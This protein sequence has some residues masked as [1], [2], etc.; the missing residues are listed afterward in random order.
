VSYLPICAD[1]GWRGKRT[2]TSGIAAHAG[3]LHSCDTYLRSQASHA[4]GQQLRAAVDRTPKP[5]HHKQANHQHGTHAC[6]VLDRCRCHPCKDANTA[7]ERTRSRQTAYG[8]WNPYVDAQPV[9]D[10]VQQLTAAGMGLKTIAKRSHV[11]HGA[12]WKLMY[13]KTRPDGTRQPSIKVRRETAQALLQLRPDLELLA[14]VAYVDATGTHRRIQALMAAGW[15]LS[16]QAQH[17]GVA[18]TNLPA[19]LHRTRVFARTALAVRA[20]YDRLASQPPAETNQRERIAAS[21][22][23]NYAAARGWPPPIWWDDDELD[24]PDVDTRDPQRLNAHDDVDEVAVL[25]ACDGEHLDLTIGERREVVRRLHAR[26]LSD[27]RIAA[28]GGLT[29]RTVLRIRQELDLPANVSAA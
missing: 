18:P 19:V 5:C 12:L 2:R 15:S 1:C 13:G 21:R 8:R 29:A 17:L 10:H 27:G 3:Q 24:T 16:Q 20:M 7:Y 6:Y 25:R 11:A 28:T 9:R 23:R 14:P 22:A 4:R 26:G